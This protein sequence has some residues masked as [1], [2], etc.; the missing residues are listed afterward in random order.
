MA[1]LALLPLATLLSASVAEDL[2]PRAR[3]EAPQLSPPLEVYLV[4]PA[5]DVPVI[6]ASA[7]AG[8]LRGY[9]TEHLVRQRCP[10][11]PDEVNS[12][13]RGAIGHD[14]DAAGRVSDITVGVAVLGPPLLDFFALGASRAFAQDLT[15]FTEAVL[16]GTLL[17]QVANFGL[18][19]PRPR[20]YAGEP[21]FVH[22]GQGYLSFYAGHV[23]T[24]AAAL[25]AASFTMRRRYGEH[26]W[27]W[28]V[29]GLITTSVGVERVLAGQHFPSDVL[30]GAVVGLAV[31]IAVPWLHA[32]SPEAQLTVTPAP[33]Q[34]LPAD[35]L[36]GA[37]VGLAVGIVVP[38]LNARAPEAQLTLT[39][40]PSGRGLA[41]LGR[42]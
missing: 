22:E 28:V 13:D 5:V 32:R 36:A 12:F 19:R 42:F 35:V 11:S 3:L 21:S 20:T 30:A 9:L 23:S 18:Q 40:A 41:L 33:G 2:A 16:V 34:H 17:H 4:R 27:P 15:V 31:G 7:T 6:A 37:G 8:L 10:C 38:W 26:V 39:P 1:M 14:S 29:T 24:T 25:S